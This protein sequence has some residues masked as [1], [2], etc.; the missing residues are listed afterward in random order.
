MRLHLNVPARAAASTTL[1]AFITDVRP[2]AAGYLPY[3]AARLA[4]LAGLAGVSVSFEPAGL[5]PLVLS[6][7]L[8]RETRSI[9]IR[10]D[11]LPGSSSPVYAAKVAASVQRFSGSRLAWHVAVLSDPHTARAQGDFLTG[12]ERY[13][14]AAEFLTIARRV[15]DQRGVDLEGEFF[16]VAGGG[17][18]ESPRSP[19]SF[20]RIYTSGTGAAALE[21]AAE[22]ADVHL[23][24]P[25]D[26]PALLPDGLAWGVELDFSELSALP[27]LARRGAVEAFI[28]GADPIATAFELAEL[29]QTTTDSVEVTR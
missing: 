12:D 21:L 20:P 24:G 7:A 14:R 4:E 18:P 27:E 19:R 11:L 6:G 5:D 3:Q 8:L 2:A 26:D 1:P 28:T 13:A 25:L 17:L 15:F 29:G 10:S 9:Q 16:A 23:L 22:H